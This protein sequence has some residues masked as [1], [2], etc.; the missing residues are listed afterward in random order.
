MVVYIIFNKSNFEQIG[1]EIFVYKNFIDFEYCKKIL[2]E[3]EGVKKWREF[4]IYNRN[5]SENDINHLI[6]V[7]EK[8][9]S[10]ISE[11]Y[12]LGNGLK[13][14]MMPKGGWCP[15][16]SDNYQFLEVDKAHSLYHEGDEFDLKDSSEYG[17]V[18][19]FNE[20]EGGDLCYPGQNIRY[21]PNPGDLIIHSAFEIAKHSISEVI[22]DNR[23]SYA[24][25]IYK[26]IK[27]P[28]GYFNGN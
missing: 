5:I 25:H 22:N 11:G 26:M 9:R 3:V 7:R 12:F 17:T 28:K 21:H 27:V 20:F 16:H 13:S 8:I 2:K 18:F 1:Q 19:Y 14:Q 4:A 23:Y 15:A 10:L 6:P 24:N